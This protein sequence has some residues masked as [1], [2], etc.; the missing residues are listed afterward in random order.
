M[1]MYKEKIKT[2]STKLDEASLNVN[3]QV[4]RMIKV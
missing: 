4:R 3:I 1:D 2:R